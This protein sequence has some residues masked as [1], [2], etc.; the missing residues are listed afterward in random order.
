MSGEN[1]V[2]QTI[3]ITDISDALMSMPE[4]RGF[5]LP[6]ERTGIRP[7]FAPE[8]TAI[9]ELLHWPFINMGKGCPIDDSNTAINLYAALVQH[10][11]THVAEVFVAEERNRKYIG[12]IKAFSVDIPNNIYDAGYDDWLME[13]LTKRVTGIARESSGLNLEPK[14]EM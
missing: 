2:N 3:Q 7:Q 14:I 11:K 9:F 6:D 8:I 1:L 4:P 13:E 5:I 12:T 10:G